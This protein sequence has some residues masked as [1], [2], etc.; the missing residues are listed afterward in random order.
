MLERHSLGPWR[1]LKYMFQHGRVQQQFSCCDTSIIL[2]KISTYYYNRLI[3][4][5]Q[6]PRI[7]S[8]TCILPLQGYRGITCFLVDR[9]AVGLTISSHED[10]LGVRASSTC[11]IHFDNVQVR[12]LLML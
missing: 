4:D 8:S 2:L 1:L 5:A 7:L 10:K 9:D 11:A 6:L 12:V 3:I